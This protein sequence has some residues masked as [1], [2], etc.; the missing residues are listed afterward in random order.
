MTPLRKKDTPV[1]VLTANVIP[2]MRERYIEEGFEDYL[3]KPVE[4]TAL[5]AV[6]KKYLPMTME[7][8]A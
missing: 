2:G 7:S 3:S 4:N 8:K 5:E 1:I 6:L